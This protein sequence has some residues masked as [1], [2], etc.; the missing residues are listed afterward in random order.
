MLKTLSDLGFGKL[1]AEVY[2][3]LALSGA[4]KASDIADGVGTYKRQI[5]R[6]IERLQ[7]RKILSG[8]QDMPANFAALPFDQLLDQL[9]KANLQEASRLEQNKN[10]IL[11]LW[12]SY[13]EKE[14]QNNDRKENRV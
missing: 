2:V 4:H 11:A 5:Y 6:T 10:N 8:T 9:A 12:N 7:S 13:I 3:Y 1:E 14:R